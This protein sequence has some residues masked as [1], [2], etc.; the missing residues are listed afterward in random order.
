MMRLSVAVPVFVG[1]VLLAGCAGGP[2]QRPED[3]LVG[4]L[5][6]RITDAGAFVHLRALQR[7][8]DQNGGNRA[9]PSP[10]YALSV[11]Y[12]VDVLREV[13]FDVSAP[14][15]EISRD[16]DHRVAL[17]NV[18]AQTRTGDPERVVMAGAH[19]DSVRKGPGIVDD[20]SGVATLLEIARNLGASP[21]VRNAVRFAFFGSEEDDR[22]GSKGYV[23][24]LSDADRRKIMLYLNVDMVASP[25]AGYF[26]QGGEG[27]RESS[28]GVA[29]SATV[30]RVLSD[31]LAKTGV[32]AQPIEF[33]GDDESAFIRAGI[34]TGGAENGDAKTKTE[35]QARAWGGH[36]GEPF[37][38]CYHSACDGLANVNRD[39]LNHYLHAIGGTITHFATSPNRL[40][41]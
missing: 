6:S 16:D 23:H 10:G 18:V 13:G 17:R 24:S 33:V 28:S 41:P 3:P 14:T 1:V 39:V 37:D 20:G 9:S 26:V 2:P 12:V 21:P 5:T 22:Q 19:L 25:N 4:R 8:A 30:A 38:A 34:P 31:Q 36:A 40:E 15:Y 7:I 11:D 29:G 32:T 27:E 35:E